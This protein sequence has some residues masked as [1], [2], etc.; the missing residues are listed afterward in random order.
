MKKTLL[1]TVAAAAVVGFTTMAS[2]Q[3]AMDSKGA[4]KPAG[5]AEQKS[6]APGGSGGAMTH[7]QPSAQAPSPATQGAAQETKPEQRM[8]DEQKPETTTPQ[9]GAEEEQKSK[10]TTPQRG[11]EEEKSQTTTPQRGAASEHGMEQKKAQEERE[12]AQKGAQSE[13][14]KGETTKSSVSQSGKAQGSQQNAGK[15]PSGAGAKVQLSQSQRT[16]IHSILGKSEAAS[17]RTNVNFNIAVGVAIPRDVHVEVLPEDVVEVVPQYE[18][19]D[20]IIVGD[21]ILIIDPDSD[22]IVAIID[23]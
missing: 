5:A 21:Q 4:A 15:A 11:A 7:Q 13:T 23:A 17:V 18:G 3:N 12:P 2:A 16:R 1:A 8:G 20:Y 19:Y 14:T 10:T 6:A 9:R 22:E